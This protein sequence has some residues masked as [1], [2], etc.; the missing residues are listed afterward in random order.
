MVNAKRHRRLALR[1]GT[2]TVKILRTRHYFGPNKFV[3]KNAICHRLDLHFLSTGEARIEPETVTRLYE[4]I[5]EL[6]SHTARWMGSSNSKT[7]RRVARLY[8]C[9][10]LELQRRAGHRVKIAKVFRAPRPGNYD[11]VHDFEVRDVGIAASLLA[12]AAL[13]DALP[14]ALVPEGVRDPG[15]DF[16]NGL[17][18]FLKFAQSHPLS[19]RLLK[20][21]RAARR[22]GILV[23]ELSRSGVIQL[24][25]GIRRRRIGSSMIADAPDLY[26]DFL[27]DRSDLYQFLHEY[28]IPVPLSLVASKPDEIGDLAR[29]LGYPV[30]IVCGSD[31]DPT[32]VVRHIESEEVLGST[33]GEGSIRGRCLVV[34]DRDLE[35]HYLFCI[36][37]TTKV[38]REGSR[39]PSPE[40]LHP[41]YIALASRTVEAIGLKQG[42]VVIGSG[43]LSDSPLKTKATVRTV[44]PLRDYQPGT[45]ERPKRSEKAML[46][47]L[48]PTIGDSRIPVCCITGSNGK[49]TT[50]Y[51][52]NHIVSM[53]GITTGLATTYGAEIEGRL[54]EKGDLAGAHTALIV[55][56]NP[57]VEAA[58][59]ETAYGGIAKFG[60]G[61]G[62]CSVGAVINVTTDHVGKSG[63]KSVEDMAEYKS[64]VVRHARDAAV[65]NADDPLSLAMKAVTS[66]STTCLVSRKNANPAILAHEQQGGATARL[67]TRDGVPFL[68]LFTGKDRIP[69]CAVDQVPLTFEGRAEHN[70]ENALFAAAI[71]YFMG[72]DPTAIA[73]GLQTFQNSF[74]KL[75]GRMNF[76]KGLPF[77]V[78]LDY[79]H[80]PEGMEMIVRF[81]DRLDI[82][83]ERICV[84]TSPGDRPDAQLV[85]L[86]RVAARHF[87]RF[88]LCPEDDLRGR[89][90]HEVPAFLRQ[91][92]AEEGISA[93]RISSEPSEEAAIDRAFEC[94][95]SRDFV[96]VFVANLDRARDQIES[97]SVEYGGVA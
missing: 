2:P 78:M 93:E 89:Q 38:V 67:T 28:G 42:E 79:A 39:E 26:R 64:I 84:L 15:F 40:N 58:I 22:R 25:Q 57:K 5:P 7:S 76:F 43:N 96:A 31:L 62:D 11:V 74:E 49:T 32:Q 10:I 37:D 16:G 53:T 69:L 85:S 48:F 87:D 61:P 97:K 77:Q 75:P 91:G 4:N 41:D 50:T 33:L 83:G 54:I 94:S 6:R 82:S 47:D 9:L 60:L 3:G 55:L 63:V 86:A 90:P 65:L 36:G 88:F 17:G 24:G 35:D 12:L 20:L 23:Q 21:A 92:L 19:G 71:S 13:I 73:K 68:E 56:Q 81:T 80:N 52:T 44:R 46:D 1:T 45:F 95:G 70:I 27:K 30:E 51:L 29:K 66:A 14:D 34:A 72:V 59:L 18:A 8:S